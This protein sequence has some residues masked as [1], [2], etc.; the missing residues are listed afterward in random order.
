MSRHR[1][2]GSKRLALLFWGVALFALPSAHA[3]TIS[4]ALSAPSAAA[5]G[6]YGQSVSDAGDV[7][8]DG[9]AD[10]IVG[11]PGDSRDGLNQGSAVI[12][13]GGTQN[14]LHLNGTLG[15]EAFGWSVAG[16]GD[17]NGD[18]F[19]DV[20]VGAPLNNAI[21]T[22][23]G[24][25]YVFYGGSAMDAVA[26]L[27]LDGDLPGDR[28]GWALSRGGDLN[29]DGWADFLVGAPLANAP[30]ADNGAVYLYLGQSG[31]P[32]T[33]YAKR[34]TGE[35]GGDQFGYSVSDVPDY[36]GDGTPAFLVGAPFV[37]QPVQNG[38]RAYLFFAVPGGL[39][40]STA[41]VVFKPSSGDPS[42]MNFGWSVSQAG[43]FDADTRTDVVIGA[44]GYLAARGLA[45]IYYG[46]A[47]PSP[48][49]SPDQIIIGETGGDSLGVSVADAGDFLGTNRTEIAIGAPSRDVPGQNAGVV[50]LFEGGSSYV[51]ASQGLVVARGGLALISPPGD[52]LGTW[53]SYAGD[54]DGDGIDDFAVGAP[55]GNNAQ[56]ALTGYVGI[57]SSSGTAVAAI[58]VRLRQIP[59]GSGRIRLEFSGP[60]AGA[61]MAS[62]WSV[63]TGGG[64]LL[65]DLSGGLLRENDILV[66]ELS[67]ASLAGVREVELRWTP[68]AGF[69]EQSQRFTLGLVPRTR[70]R[71]LPPSPN[72]FNP[73]TVVRFELPERMDVTLRVLDV[74]GRVVRTLLV[75]PAGPGRLE[76]RF[77]GRDDRGRI[78][79]T[80]VYH[81]V[82]EGEGMRSSTRAVLV[83]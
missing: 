22:E 4:S 43:L 3:Q 75:G 72:P 65:A 54:L 56:N 30:A 70:F 47:S 82:L 63:E 24:R 17:V 69:A 9:V 68:A 25:V 5:G 12:F 21:G 27:V 40:S 55:D 60:A 41:D 59:L 34:F 45:A 13:F 10:L 31:G 49:P 74:R 26:D 16:I 62:L 80:G 52:R 77:D 78:L 2:A 67:S 83:K 53:V 37:D 44:P 38:G 71:L 73:A 7:N 32:S 29:G 64:R 18:G 66:A 28:F 14:R 33:N 11:S 35:I 19:D 79:A 8:G 57:V 58:P 6:L 81:L 61:S 50:Y 23:Q 1:R 39:P 48:L 76:L 42:D 15:R 20:A 36:K 51:N 46:Q